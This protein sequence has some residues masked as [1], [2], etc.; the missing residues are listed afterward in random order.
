[1]SIAINSNG[2]TSTSSSIID[3]ATV[4]YIHTISIIVYIHRTTI[5]TSIIQKANPIQIHA[6]LAIEV[7]CTSINIFI[8]KI[9]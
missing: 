5:S 8:S 7:N 3:K 4:T 6:T 9:R 1:M 2:S